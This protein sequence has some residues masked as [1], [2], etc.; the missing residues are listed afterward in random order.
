MLFI[1][2]TRSGSELELKLEDVIGVRAERSRFVILLFAAN[3]CIFARLNFIARAIAHVHRPMMWTWLPKNRCRCL[4]TPNT[5]PDPNS[6]IYLLPDYWRHSEPCR[7]RI[8]GWWETKS[9]SRSLFFGQ[10]L[11]A[12]VACL[13]GTLLGLRWLA[14]TRRRSF[15]ATLTQSSNHPSI[16]VQLENMSCRF[17]L[18]L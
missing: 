12:A 1:I 16:K 3:L 14:S 13:W 5:D 8:L 10:S 11:F 15:G 9:V 6:L 17:C 7:S 18:H 4:W 2:V